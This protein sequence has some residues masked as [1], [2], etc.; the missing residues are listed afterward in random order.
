MPVF[1]DDA[2][3]RIYLDLLDELVADSCVSLF[4]YAL[5]PNHIHLLLRPDDDG[6]SSFMQQLQN[7]Y[8]KYHRRIRN[9]TGH[10]WQG[11][12][13]HKH[14]VDDVYLYAVGN[15]IEMNPVRA[16]LVVEP[17]HWLYSSFRHYAFGET[18]RLITED[19][20]YLGL[21][22]SDEERQATYRRCV[23]KTRQQL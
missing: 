2:D 14:I 15:Y 19:P 20:L 10:L 1:R 23:S 8:A 22:K 18:I 4:H 12:F 16:G 6:I 3:Y 21:G 7:R 9:H 5:M 17:A 11:R 13:K